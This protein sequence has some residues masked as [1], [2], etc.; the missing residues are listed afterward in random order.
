LG[1][2]CGSSIDTCPASAKPWVQAPVLPKKK[3]YK[4]CWVVTCVHF[5]FY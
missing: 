1:W 3:K 4:N 2:R 5:Q